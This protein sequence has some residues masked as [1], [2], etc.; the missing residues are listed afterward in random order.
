MED[1]QRAQAHANLLTLGQRIRSLRHQC[2]LT[3]EQLAHNSGAHRTVIGFIER[4]ER[5]IGV[6]QLWPLASALGVEVAE[7]FTPDRAE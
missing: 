6:S 2:G 1:Q 5:D 4:G 7:L 3:Q